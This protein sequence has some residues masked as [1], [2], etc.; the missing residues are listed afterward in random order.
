LRFIVRQVP[1]AR[2]AEDIDSA[3]LVVA[4][5]RGNLSVF[6]EL[7]LRYF[8]RIYACARVTLR[9]S[10][11]AEI[12]TQRVF[13][14]ALEWLPALPLGGA[15]TFRSWLFQIAAARIAS[16]FPAH[17]RMRRQQ[18]PRPEVPRGPEGEVPEQTGLKLFS[19]ADI[20]LFVEELPPSQ[21]EVLALRYVLEM[22]FREIATALDL[23]PNTVGQLHERALRML[24]GRLGQAG[25][26]GDRTNPAPMRRRSTLS[27]VLTT[28][29]L[30]LRAAA[31][32][33]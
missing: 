26:G 32:A 12:V 15:R 11:D 1:G 20:Y 17:I 23:D 22:S 8:D 3:R 13:T 7:Y 10:L 29:R 21:R 4:F 30:A 33:R 27:P 31:A 28:R 16:A 24:R 14:L 9:D 19:D 18:S 6:E 5:Q 25:P 2:A